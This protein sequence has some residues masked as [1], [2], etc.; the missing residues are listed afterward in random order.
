ML[1]GVH[2]VAVGRVGILFKV[3]DFFNFAL[4]VFEITQRH[5][6]AVDHRPTTQKWI[7]FKV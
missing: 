1:G 5:F 6:D 4:D 3:E 2:F 7:Y